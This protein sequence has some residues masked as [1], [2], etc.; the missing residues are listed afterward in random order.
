MI[1]AEKFGLVFDYPSAGVPAYVAEASSVPR[2]LSFL[3]VVTLPSPGVLLRH[4]KTFPYRE[5]IRNEQQF[6]AHIPRSWDRRSFWNLTAAHLERERSVRTIEMCGPH[7][8]STV[9]FGC[10]RFGQAAFVGPFKI[11]TGAIGSA[12]I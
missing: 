2:R 11:W 4:R 6:R 5:R 3:S 1:P 10:C 8:E 7:A 9:D 12:R